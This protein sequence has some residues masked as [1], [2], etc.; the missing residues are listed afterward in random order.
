MLDAI[1]PASIASNMWH[2]Q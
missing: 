1:L 2:Y